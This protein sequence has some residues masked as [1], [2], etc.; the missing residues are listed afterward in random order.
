MSELFFLQRATLPSMKSKNSPRGIKARAAHR[1][2][3]LF[4]F[5]MQ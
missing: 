3:K 4:G 5:P 2:F 1:L